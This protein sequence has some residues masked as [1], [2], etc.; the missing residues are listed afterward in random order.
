MYATKYLT[1]FCLS[2]YITQYPI[3]IIAQSTSHFTSLV[4]MFNQ[5]PSQFTWEASSHML[6]LMREGCSYTCPPLSIALSSFIQL[7]ELEQ[8]SVKNLVQGFNTAAQDLNPGT[9]SRESEGLP[10]RSMSHIDI[11]NNYGKCHYIQRPQHPSL[12]SLVSWAQC[13]SWEL[14][15]THNGCHVGHARLGGFKTK[16]PDLSEHDAKMLRN[17][18]VDVDMQALW[19]TTRFCQ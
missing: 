4:Y 1:F 14:Y 15:S 12:P 7:S 16:F 8:C 3:L 13:W 10:Q 6:Q 18:F 9:L 5:T 19:R 17:P 2:S 11:V